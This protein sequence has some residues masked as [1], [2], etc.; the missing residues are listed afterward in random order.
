MISAYYDL[1]HSVPWWTLELVS[2]LCNDMQFLND[3]LCICGLICIHEYAC[4]INPL[5]KTA[6]SQVWALSV[7]RT[8]N[9]SA[10]RA[11]P[12]P[13]S[14]TCQGP[15]VKFKYTRYKNIWRGRHR[16]RRQRKDIPQMLPKKEKN[17]PQV[18][19]IE[20]NLKW[21]EIK[22]PFHRQLKIH[23]VSQWRGGG[24]LRTHT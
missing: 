22:K 17:K 3:C 1:F 10:H 8:S 14:H 2:A 21:S 13:W 9:L 18:K 23:T 4:R 19:R 5:C 6:E 16:Y 7:H 20:F 24:V 11:I 15:I 12:H